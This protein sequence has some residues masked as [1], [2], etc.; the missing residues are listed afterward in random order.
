MIRASIYKV[1]R[2]ILLQ[3]FQ[4][5]IVEMEVGVGCVGGQRALRVLEGFRVSGRTWLRNFTLHAVLCGFTGRSL[6]EK[7]LQIYA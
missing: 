6:V 5:S 7:F 2:E 4:A 3:T 1:Y